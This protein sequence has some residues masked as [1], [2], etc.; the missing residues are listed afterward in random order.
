MYIKLFTQQQNCI[1]AGVFVG[2]WFFFTGVLY[3]IN[4]LLNIHI[5]HGLHLISWV[6]VFHS[7]IAM[8]ALDN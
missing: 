5:F 3:S 7:F 6:T 8:N 2:L 1:S 4:K